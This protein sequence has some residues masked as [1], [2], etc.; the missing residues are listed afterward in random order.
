MFS[1]LRLMIASQGSSKTWMLIVRPPKNPI[2]A[3]QS[4]PVHDLGNRQTT[5]LGRGKRIDA[6]GHSTVN[7]K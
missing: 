1:I 3:Q 7:S 2:S 6:S 4:I 5:E